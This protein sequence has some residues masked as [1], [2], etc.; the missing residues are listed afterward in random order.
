MMRG[1]LVLLLLLGAGCGD[2]TGFIAGVSL[3]PRGNVVVA[4]AG[5]NLIRV[6]S[7]IDGTELREHRTG[8][9]SPDDVAA[10]PNGELWWTSLFTGEVGY[11]DASGKA[12]ILADPGIGVNAIALAPDGRLLVS[13][14]F[15]GDDLLSLNPYVAGEPTRLW[16]DLGEECAINGMKFG[17]DGWLYGTQPPMGRVVRLNLADKTIE[18]LASGLSE[19]AY[20][21]ALTPEG[22][23]FALDGRR[24]VRVLEGGAVEPFVELPNVGD[25]MVF[26]ADGSELFVSTGADMRVLGFDRQGRQRVLLEGPP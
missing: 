3:D 19:Q 6:V 23:V 25:N 26:S 16:E 8:V 21:V 4:Y 14:C 1:V 22:E 17:R 5:H 13:Q 24:V 7:P 18:V 12:T 15:G 11:A 9:R 10:G 20:A 2:T